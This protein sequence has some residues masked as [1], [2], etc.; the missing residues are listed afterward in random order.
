M[1]LDPS[2][3]HDLRPTDEASI[4]TVHLAMDGLTRDDSVQHAVEVLRKMVGVQDVHGENASG[5]ITVVFD[6]R[7]T[8][9]PNLHDGLL[10]A[11]YSPARTATN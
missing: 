9:V 11:G 7:K 1:S 4:E 3:P 6:A 2:D 10:Q 8:H 5:I